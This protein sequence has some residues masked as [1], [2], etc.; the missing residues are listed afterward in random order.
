MGTHYQPQTNPR[1]T[2]TSLL[3][4]LSKTLPSSVRLQFVSLQRINTSE[5]NA[6]HSIRRSPMAP[7]AKDK[8]K[9]SP[10]VQ[11]QPSISLEDLFSSLHR[12][13]QNF[14]YDQAVKVADQGM[15]NQSRSHPLSQ[16]PNLS[17]SLMSVTSFAV[18]AIAP[19]DEDALRCK[20]VALIKS[21]GIDRAL[22]TI[23]ASQNIPIDLR[24]YKVLYP[25]IDLGLL[26]FLIPWC[27]ICI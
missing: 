2:T 6:F 15:I 20:I 23:Q 26:I 14:E 3:H 17:S 5:K 4:A 13:I 12:H 1:P 16:S 11:S 27:N 24:F 19:G 10:L 9:P 22:S 25:Q 18:L 21:D 7:K 8:P